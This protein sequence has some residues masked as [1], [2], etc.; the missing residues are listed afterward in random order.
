MKHSFN[1]WDDM[2]WATAAPPEAS[3]LEGWSPPKIAR[4]YVTL[5]HQIQD[6][7]R[8]AEASRTPAHEER[9]KSFLDNT[10]LQNPIDEN[11]NI[12][13]VEALL[14]EAE[15]L[16][17]LDWPQASYFRGLSASLTELRA[18]QATQG[19]VP[20]EGQNADMIGGAGAS[21]PPLTPDFGPQ[22]KKPPGT[23]LPG[24]EVPGEEGPP[25]DQLPGTPVPAEN[26]SPEP[27]AAQTIRA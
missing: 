18:W 25:T 21:M 24:E 15:K 6:L 14:K 2:A 22:E 17:A 13:V 23:E 3:I 16:S 8:K 11:V 20:P 27:E 9:L 5:T 1:S 10:W 26:E 7:V 19:T 12:E 4:W